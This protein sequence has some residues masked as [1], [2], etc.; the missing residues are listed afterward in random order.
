MSARAHV[1]ACVR[2]RVCACVCVYVHALH[3]LKPDSCDSRPCL[4]FLLIQ[5]AVSSCVC[6]SV[7]IC[8]CVSVCMCMYVRV[9]KCVF[10][11]VCFCALVLLA[12]PPCGQGETTTGDSFDAY[13]HMH[14]DDTCTQTD[15]R[16][17]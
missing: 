5:G 11:L 12:P 3:I 13:T 1:C 17:D 4:R 8:M 9:W 15:K 14:N 6:M 10:V 7:C 2:V 16:S